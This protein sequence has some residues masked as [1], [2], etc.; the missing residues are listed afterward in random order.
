MSTLVQLIDGQIVQSDA[1]EWLWECFARE[2]RARFPALEDRS[3]WL[4]DFAR[5]N[6]Q[7]SANKLH[8]AMTVLWEAAK[9]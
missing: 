7:Q 6:G 8:D 4:A 5:M 3:A 1:E 2:V 9:I